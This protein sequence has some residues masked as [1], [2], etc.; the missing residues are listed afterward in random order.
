[1]VSE[2]REEDNWI[3]DLF[4]PLLDML[5]CVE[6][7]EIFTFGLSRIQFIKNENDLTEPIWDII[8]YM[9]RILEKMM[10]KYP[11]IFTTYPEVPWEKYVKIGKA[12]ENGYW[13][14]VYQLCW[15]LVTKGIVQ[16]KSVILNLFYFAADQ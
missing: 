5:E 1:M 14:M 11:E 4:Y 2:K 8:I 12:L 15:R 16:I 10:E 7:I 3:E 9:G 6:V 13:N